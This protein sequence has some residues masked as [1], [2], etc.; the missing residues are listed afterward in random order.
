MAYCAA[1]FVGVGT[2]HN[3]ILTVHSAV[4]LRAGNPVPC[5]VQHKI[6]VVVGVVVNFVD[7]FEV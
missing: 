7:F 6:A 5:V 1:L 3:Y 4:A 2:D